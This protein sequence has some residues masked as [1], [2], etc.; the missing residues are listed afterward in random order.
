MY[1]SYDYDYAEAYAV[2]L[3]MSRKPVE[4]FRLAWLT[5]CRSTLMSFL[6]AYAGGLALVEVQQRGFEAA[7]AAAAAAAA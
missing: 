2:H 5:Q 3:W 4:G 1:H 7:A 6:S